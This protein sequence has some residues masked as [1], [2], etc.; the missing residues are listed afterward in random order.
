[1]Y[2]QNKILSLRTKP[3]HRNPLGSNARKKASAI[4][5]I[6]RKRRLFYLCWMVLVLFWFV[7]E[8][9][10]QQGKIWDQQEKLTAMQNEL[11][12]SQQQNQQVKQ[13]V[14]KLKSPSYLIE[15]VHKMGYS[16][17]EEENYHVEQNGSK[18][19][20]MKEA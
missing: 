20:K 8:L 6:V 16:K 2:Q 3:I 1:M 14:Q 11:T 7:V 18:N 17:P 5:P 13:R 10:I 15:L 9:I 4:H 12:T 19:N